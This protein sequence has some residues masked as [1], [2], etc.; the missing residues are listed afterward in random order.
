MTGKSKSA[1][2][3][4]RAVEADQFG[5]N[6][7]QGSVGVVTGASGGIGRAITTA[8]ARYGTTLCAVGRNP[9]TLGSTVCEA[10]L[11][12]KVVP[13]E[14]DLTVDSDIKRIE[15]LLRSNFGRLDILVHC[16]GVI[17]HNR[18]QNARIEHLDEQ[19]AADVRAPYLLTKSLLP[20]LR[21]SKGQIVFI[22]SSL[23]MNA[24]R[25]EVGQ[26]AATQHA[27]RAI[28][29]SLREEVNPDGIRVLSVYPGRTATPRMEALYKTDGFP[30]Q[31]DLLMQPQDIAAM[32]VAALLL[33]RTAEVTDITMRPMRKSY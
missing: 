18:M 8:L 26:F 19:Y 9:S 28:T 12:S 17:H 2:R 11:Y 5:D 22:N 29:E 7:L 13:I 31:A 14:A 21:G 33:P 4:T 10:Q 3:V 1:Q 27:L 23:G 30:Y 6:S 20:L 32:V 24:K 16:A 15:Q 25:A